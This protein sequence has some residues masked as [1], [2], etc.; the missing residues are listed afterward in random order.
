MRGEQN[1]AAGGAD[2]L[3]IDKA[4]GHT[5]VC[6]FV[7]MRFSRLILRVGGIVD[8]RRILEKQSKIDVSE[9]AVEGINSMTASFTESRE[10]VELIPSR[11][12][13]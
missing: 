11:S 3:V 5:G 4:V 6:K 12:T 1:D 7:P 2:L 13:R 10:F 8:Y 9:A